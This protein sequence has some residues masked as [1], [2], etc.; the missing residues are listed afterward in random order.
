MPAGR[1][2]AGAPERRLRASGNRRG[3]QNSA[4][5]RIPSPRAPPLA[6]GSA[7][8]GTEVVI[9]AGDE[10]LDGHR[11]PV[12]ARRRKP[13]VSSSIRREKR[14][15]RMGRDTFMSAQGTSGGRG[16]RLRKSQQARV[17]HGIAQLSQHA[18]RREQQSSGNTES[19]VSQSPM[20]AGDS[21]GNTRV[22]VGGS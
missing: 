20:R 10:Q 12:P 3:G 16:E 5:V 13:Q 7:D 1:K 8:D 15:D 6:G 11:P 14:I 22:Q 18:R 2:P 17:D 9:V 19:G 4:S 21:L